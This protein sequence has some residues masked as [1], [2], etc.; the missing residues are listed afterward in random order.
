[1]QGGSVLDASPGAIAAA[2]AA[3]GAAAADPIEKRW[4]TSSSSRTRV[5]PD[6][7]TVTRSSKTSVGVSVDPAGLVGLVDTFFTDGGT[8]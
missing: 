8:Q 2:G 4:T 3:A 1:V 7:S 5:Q 6:G